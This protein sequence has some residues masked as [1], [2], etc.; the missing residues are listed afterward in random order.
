MIVIYQL[1]DGSSY[2][3][4]KGAPE[5][6]LDVCTQFQGKTPQKVSPLDKKKIESIEKANGEMGS[7]VNRIYILP[8][9]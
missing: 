6:V 9:S 8:S 7:K 2:A 5:A 1:P 3:L 4:V